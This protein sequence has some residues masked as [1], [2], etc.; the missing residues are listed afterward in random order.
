M[1]R[2]STHVLDTSRG[3]PAPGIARRAA[4]CRARPSAG[5]VAVVGHQRRRPHRSRRCSPATGSSRRLRTDVPRRRLPFRRGAAVADPPFLDEIVIR[6]G[7]ADRERPLP[8]AAAA[9]AVRLQ[10]VPGLVTLRDHARP[11][12]VSRCRLLAT[13]TE[14]PGGTTRTF[15]SPPMRGVHAHLHGLDGTTAA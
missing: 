5:C 6:V 7:I 14:E 3:M 10:H 15:L 13:H 1:A 8:R 9:L 12:R 4:P 11:S 2:L